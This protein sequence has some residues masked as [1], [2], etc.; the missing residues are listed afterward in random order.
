[1]PPDD[2]DEFMFENIVW[3]HIPG[4]SG[5]SPVEYMIELCSAER[6]VNLSQLGLDEEDFEWSF[7]LEVEGENQELDLTNDCEGSAHSVISLPLRPAWV[8]NDPLVVAIDT[9]IV[10]TF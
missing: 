9:Q 4:L 1:M 3:S 5:D 7:A 8:T 10:Q 2:P 6:R